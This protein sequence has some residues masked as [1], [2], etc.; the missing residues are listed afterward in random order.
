[1][2]CS[3][4]EIDATAAVVIT[5]VNH[6]SFMSLGGITGPFEHVS[7]CL[8]LSKSLWESLGQPHSSHALICT[9]VVINCGVIVILIS[10]IYAQFL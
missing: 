7:S 4:H 5:G 6:T 8:K 1:L 9:E 3:L 10:D 2:E